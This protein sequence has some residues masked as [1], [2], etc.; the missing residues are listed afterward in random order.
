MRKVLIF[1]NSGAGKTT[2]ARQLAEQEGLAH[3]DLDT[4]AWKPGGTVPE[5]AGLELSRQSMEAFIAANDAWVIEGCYADLHGLVVDYA[6]EAIFVN[7]TVERCVANARQRP[8]EPHKYSSRAAQDKNLEMLIAWIRA[9]P[10][11]EDACGYRAHVRLFEA[12]EG[13]RF[14]LDQM[15]PPFAPI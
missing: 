10:D 2:L 15:S 1:G 8:W 12:F 4:V 5:R 13:K 14:M 3:F 6:N 7:P 9:Y 11:R